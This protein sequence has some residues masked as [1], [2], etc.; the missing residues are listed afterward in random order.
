MVCGF[1]KMDQLLYEWDINGQPIQMQYNCVVWL[2][3]V[4]GIRS[5]SSEGVGVGTVSLVI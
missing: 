3:K 4:S 5:G 2:V 1:N